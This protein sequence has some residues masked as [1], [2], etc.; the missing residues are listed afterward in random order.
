MNSSWDRGLTGR[1]GVAVSPS[2]RQT[3]SSSGDSCGHSE[4]SSR[5]AA[6]VASSMPLAAD[7][8][9][10]KLPPVP[11]SAYTQRTFRANAARRRESR[12]R[13]EVSAPTHCRPRTR[14]SPDRCALRAKPARSRTRVAGDHHAPRALCP[15]ARRHPLRRAPARRRGASEAHREVQ[16]TNSARHSSR[17]SRKP[18]AT[19]PTSSASL[20]CWARSRARRS[21]SA[22]KA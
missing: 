12:E 20:R 7:S 18:A 16:D 17:I 4:S 9:S 22:S 13:G 15:R 1:V 8:S 10:A 3:P 19:S 5:S 6:V 21:A 2:A 14:L 11:R